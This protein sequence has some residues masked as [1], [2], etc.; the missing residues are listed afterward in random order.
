MPDAD[1]LREFDGLAA[2]F[3]GHFDEADYERRLEP[4]SGSA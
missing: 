2:A 4:R 3:L 1:R